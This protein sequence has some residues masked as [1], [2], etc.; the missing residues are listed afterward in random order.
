MPLG[1]HERVAA[2]DLAETNARFGPEVFGH[3][4]VFDAYIED[5]RQQHGCRYAVGGYAELRAMYAISPVFDGHAQATTVLE[6]KVY[7][8]YAQPA[9]EP[10]RLHLGL[11]VWGAAGTPVSAPI[12]GMIHSTGYHSSLGNYGGVVI[13]SHQLNGLSF[14]TL[15][16]HLS[17]ASAQQW[18]DGMYVS[19][20]Q[21]IGELGSHAENG[22]WPPHLHL[23]LMADME[24]FEGD[25]PG[26][27]RFSERERFL[28]NCLPPALL[29]PWM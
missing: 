23:Q 10:R 24:G 18:A 2:I 20:G 15:Y 14:Y 27:C 13:L 6:D 21:T 19:R 28:A 26:V 17:A 8:G 11:D 4:A 12:G 9:H 5:Y 22:Q 7:A 16:G 1:P 29:I 3:A 25:Y